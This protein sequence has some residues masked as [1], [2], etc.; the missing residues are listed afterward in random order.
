M[1]HTSLIGRFCYYHGLTITPT[2]E[3]VIQQKTGKIELEQEVKTNNKAPTHDEQRSL[4][5]QLKVVIDD[6]TAKYKGN[7]ICEIVGINDDGYIMLLEIN[8]GKLHRV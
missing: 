1:H 8:T 7:Y 4:N 2:L 3:E 6:M 5:I